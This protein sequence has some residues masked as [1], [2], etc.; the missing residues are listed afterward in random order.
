MQGARHLSPAD[1]ESPLVSR[2]KRGRSAPKRRTYSRHGLTT[3]KAAVRELGTR[4]VDRRTSMGRALTAWKASL[5]RDLGAD[6]GVQDLAIVD[7]AVRAK[8]IL[9]SIDAWLLTQSSLVNLRRR[10]LLPAVRERQQLADAF[11]RYMTTLGLER[12]AATPDLAAQFARLRQE[13]SET[14]TAPE[15]PIGKPDGTRP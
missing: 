9:D 12:R 8:L 6:P 1:T 4:A 11:A 15:T 14:P 7:L 13:G 2:P 3:L 5:V 10:A